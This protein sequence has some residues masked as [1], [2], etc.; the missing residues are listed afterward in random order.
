MEVVGRLS[1]AGRRAPEKPSRRATASPS[2]TGLNSI[3]E[4]GRS[5]ATVISSRSDRR[6]WPSWSF[7][8]CTR[9][10]R[11]SREELLGR[12]WRGVRRQRADVDVY[13]SRSAKDRARS[14]QSIH[15]AD[16]AGLGYLFDPP[17]ASASD[18]ENVNKPPTPR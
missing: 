17:S 15:F 16:R 2:A 18:L 8:R 6:S 10:A 12:V 13:V 3:S 4:Q 7:W 9:A 14:G 11:F 5:A 1:I